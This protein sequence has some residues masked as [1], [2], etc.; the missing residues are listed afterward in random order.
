M[1]EVTDQPMPYERD[2]NTD[3]HTPDHPGNA[4]EDEKHQ[5]QRRL[6]QHPCHFKEAIEPILRDTVFNDKSRRMIERDHAMHLPEGVLKERSAVREEIV[7]GLLALRPIANV[8]GVD[9]AER[10]GHA[11]KHTEGDED[12]LEPERRL[13]RAMDQ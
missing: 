5:R 11:D 13:K 4:T 6:L 9:H 12:A 2:G 7:A 10:P 1:G 8:M 3:R